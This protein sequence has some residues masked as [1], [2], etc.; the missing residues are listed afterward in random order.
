MT[1]VLWYIDSNLYVQEDFISF[2][3]CKI[4]LTGKNLASFLIEKVVSFVLEIEN[5]RGQ[6]YDGA[7]NVAGPKSGLAAEITRLNSKAL[8]MHCFNYKLNL[9]VANAF[10]ITNVQN[11][12][13][14][15]KQGSR[16]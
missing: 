9:S 13:I 14:I 5:C 11:F 10:K 2:V 3:H 16:F 1:L 12:L 7:G 8:Y 6:V 4:D 15:H